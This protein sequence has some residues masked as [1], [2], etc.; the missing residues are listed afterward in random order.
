MMDVVFTKTGS[1]ENASV[2]SDGKTIIMIDSGIKPDIIRKS[3]NYKLS[4][5]EGVIITHEHLD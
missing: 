1:K 2:I 4:K 5:L 3:T